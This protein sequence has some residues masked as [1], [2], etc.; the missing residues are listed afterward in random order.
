MIRAMW[1]LAGAMSFSLAVQADVPDPDPGRFSDPI[2]SF[3][4]WDSKNSFPQDGMLFVGSSSIRM[5]STATAFP[6]RPIINR[7]FG[8]S[9]LSDVIHFYDQVVRPYQPSAIFLYAGD[10]DVAGGKGA[11]QVFDDYKQFVTLVQAGLPDSKLFFI[12]I[13]PSL[14][15]WSLWPTMQDAND[16]IREYTLKHPNLGYIDLASPL[17]NDTGKPMDVFIEDGLH[18]NAK[19]YALWQQALAPYLDF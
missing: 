2:E 4:L 6:G 3:V 5:W 15:R 12:S 11:D 14:S 16:K 18:L 13:K 9:E 8:G 1:L 17:L 7:G 10:N 19:G